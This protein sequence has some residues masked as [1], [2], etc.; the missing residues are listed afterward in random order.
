MR[1]RAK[2]QAEQRRHDQHRRLQ[3]GDVVLCVNSDWDTAELLGALLDAQERLSRSPTQRLVARKR[4]EQFLHG[5]AE[6]SAPHTD[7]APNG[8]PVIDEKEAERQLLV[9]LNA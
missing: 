4:G 1:G 5:P 3:L 2:A 7:E 6:D 8:V 9:A